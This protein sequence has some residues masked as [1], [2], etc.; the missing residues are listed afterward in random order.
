MGSYTNFITK[1]LK[2]KSE[3]PESVIKLIDSKVNKQ[4]D[5]EEAARPYLLY[6]GEMGWNV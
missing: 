2:L 4:F 1:E 6:S 5:F 3:T